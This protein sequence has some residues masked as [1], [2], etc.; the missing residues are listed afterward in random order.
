MLAAIR[1]VELAL[2]YLWWHNPRVMLG[3]FPM[4]YFFDVADLYML[5]RFIVLAPVAIIEAY[6]S[7][8]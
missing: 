1:I 3:Q 6:R 8:P 2:E 4:T 5:V 7:T